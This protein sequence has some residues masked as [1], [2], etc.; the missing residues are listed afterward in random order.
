MI[1]LLEVTTIK[2]PLRVAISGSKSETN[3][4]LLLQAFYP[5]LS[6]TN[7]A[8]A[9]DTI[10]MQKALAT[11]E[12]TVNIHHAGTAMRF[13]TAYYATQVDR[14]VLLTG[15]KRMTERPIG[16]LV[17]ALRQLGAN[18]EYLG[19]EGYPPLRI[20]GKQLTKYKVALSASVSSQYISALLLIAPQ[21]PNGLELTLEGTVTS[22]PYIKMTLALLYKMGIEYTFE[23]NVIKVKHQS[24]I[25]NVNFTIESDWSSASYWYSIIALSK[26]GTQVTLTSYKENSLQG[27][28][29][30]AQ[31]FEDFGVT[32]RFHNDTI[33]I[34]KTANCKLS[35]INYTLD[36][37]PDLAQTIAVTCFGLGLKCNLTGL[38][39]LKVKETDRLVALQNELQKLGGK[40]TI[41]ED[42]ISITD[43]EVLPKTPITISTYNDHRM[44]MA[45]APLAVVFPIAIENIAVVSKS[46]PKFWEDLEQ[47]G[48]TIRIK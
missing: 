8:T 14:E 46:Y 4:L 33:T 1:H 28:A 20:K 23:N 10:V 19:N 44:A 48:F 47:F 29:Q 32:T 16:I 38:H 27:D 21:L 37:T 42:R 13:L 36:H 31:L 9:D 7:L 40:V 41:T 30:I 12:D 18:I 35:S 5:N 26:I 15:S 2:Q 39:T 43:Y 24:E 6:I 11:K 25:D 22:L 3:R 34:Q 45:F 17:E